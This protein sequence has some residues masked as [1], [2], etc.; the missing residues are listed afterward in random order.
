VSL[1][2]PISSDVFIHAQRSG[3][4][5]VLAGEKQFTIYV[6]WRARVLLVL[7]VRIVK[8]DAIR[9]MRIRAKLSNTS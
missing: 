2:C 3:E 9:D 4:L 7:Q 6:G 5:L 1:A 8:L